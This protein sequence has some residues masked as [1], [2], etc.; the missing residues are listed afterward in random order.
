M[1]R[2]FFVNRPRIV[3]FRYP[4]FRYSRY[5]HSQDTP[6]N[7]QPSRNQDVRDT[8]TEVQGNPDSNWFV[9]PEYVEADVQLQKRLSGKLS[10]KAA[11][12][13][14]VKDRMEEKVKEDALVDD[15]RQY[16]INGKLTLEDAICMLRDELHAENLIVIDMHDKCTWTG[17]MLIVEG[18]TDS[19]VRRIANGFKQKVKQ[20]LA[21][22]ESVLVDSDSPSILT[23]THS[24]KLTVEG[25]DCAD[26]KLV[27]LGHIVVHVFTPEARQEYNLEELWNNASSEDEEE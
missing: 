5:L 2:I 6:T 27:D 16:A 8:V 11:M 21:Q 13:E 15:Q 3:S 10:Q 26:W 7:L 17:H 12:P 1:I 25:E 9:D 18:R 19:H 23:P 14:W 22:S 4:I 20:A 24:T